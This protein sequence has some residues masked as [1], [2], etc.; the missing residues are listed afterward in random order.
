[1]N[2]SKVLNFFRWM[3][4]LLFIGL[5]VFFTYVLMFDPANQTPELAEKRVIIDG[6][7]IKGYEKNVLSWLLKARNMWVGDYEYLVFLTD[8][9][10]GQVFDNAK[11]TVLK[12]DYAKSMKVNYR[13]KSIYAE[14]IKVS[15]LGN[16]GP[17]TDGLYA[18]PNATTRNIQISATSFKYYSRFKKA[19]LSGDVEIHRGDS[20]MKVNKEIEVDLDANIAYVEQ[21]F[22][23]VKGALSASANTMIL[24]IDEE[25]AVVKGELTLVRTPELGNQVDDREEQLKQVETVMTGD[26]LEYKTVDDDIMVRITGNVKIKQPDKTAEADYALFDGENQLYRLNGN[27]VIEGDSLDWLLDTTRKTQFEDQMVQ[28]AIEMPFSLAGQDVVFDANREQLVVKGSVVFEQDDKS[29]QCG[30]L[31]MDDRI[32]KIELK[33]DVSIKKGEDTLKTNHLVYDWVNEVYFIE[34][35]MRAEF[36]IE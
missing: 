35:G 9:Y 11:D 31:L 26:G 27:V 36:Q 28:D 5:A 22:T 33:Q 19:F 32:G 1:M 25:R 13:T 10:D 3:V 21:G 4:G 16:R 12:I 7:V 18:S 30:E 20:I 23:F 6:S 24:Y 8:A 17:E 14:D 2:F 15:L 34:S 29:I